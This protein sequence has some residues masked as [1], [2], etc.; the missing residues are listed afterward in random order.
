MILLNLSMASFG[1]KKGWLHQL[2]W[3]RMSAAS[4]TDGHALELTPKKEIEETERTVFFF[5]FF[6]NLLFARTVEAV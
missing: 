3:E 1:K 4:G 5:F 6:A 2:D